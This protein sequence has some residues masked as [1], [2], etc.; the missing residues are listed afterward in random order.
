MSFKNT[1]IGLI[2]SEWDFDTIG[3]SLYI[4]G[5]IGWKG[6]KKSEY[7]DKSDYRIING[8]NV[9]NNNIDWSG[10]GYISEERYEESPEIMLKPNDIVMTKD[11][12]IGKLAII[13][14]LEQKT[15]VASGLFVIRVE[16]NSIDVD[17]LYYYFSSFY[18]K[19]LVKSRIEGSVIPHLYQKDLVALKLP[20][21]DL[22]EQKAIS[23]I[24]RTLDDKIEVNNQINKTLENM[25][26]TI[27]KQ[28]F[29]DFE[30][31]NE[32]GE[33]YKSS[34][35][36]MVESELGMIPKGWEVKGLDEIAE[37]LNGLAMQKFRPAETE[38][39]Y[40]VLKIKE[41]RQGRTDESSDLCSSNIDEKYI[42]KDGDIIF[43]WSGS[44]LVD[45]WCGGICGLNQHLFKVTSNKFDEWF[46]YQW[47]K[48]HLDRFDRI[49]KS[50]ATTMG[51]IKRKDLS[52]SKVLVPSDKMYL[53]AAQHQKYLFEKMKFLKVEMKR[54]EKIRDSLLPKL[55]SGKI[56][57]PLD[58]E[59]D[60]S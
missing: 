7:I 1:D 36:E 14:S 29:V 44:L 58:S 47:N 39:A 53:K 30:F 60:V 25:A 11:G 52:D 2:P 34:G 21:P 43:S 27:F 35:G 33:P 56:R 17:Y 51:H 6:L 48:Y 50:K 4:K 19:E 42:V 59:G 3:D 24:L 37:F 18:F 5:R 57:V 23:K 12:T 45:I 9:V 8:S 31:P 41:L 38:K 13:R 10:C 40:P 16:D 32:D 54:L 15:T 49:A 55:M 26:Q 20:L 28:W 22:S 46:I